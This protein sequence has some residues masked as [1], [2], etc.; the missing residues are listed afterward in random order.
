M[1]R[2]DE[3]GYLTSFSTL[4]KKKKTNQTWRIK[5]TRKGRRKTLK[6]YD[7]EENFNSPNENYPPPIINFINSSSEEEKKKKTFGKSSI[8]KRKEKQG[9]E[10][11]EQQVVAPYG[12][13]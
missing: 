5:W 4:K 3:R 12:R 10:G 6:S 11:V 1:K 2:G 13:A 8:R 7:D 9:T